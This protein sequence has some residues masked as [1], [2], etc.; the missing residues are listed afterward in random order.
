M[1]QSWSYLE[2][3]IVCKFYLN[4]VETWRNHID[5]L[6]DSLVEAGFPDRDK[7]S[8]RMR[9]QNYESL[10]IGKGLS[11]AGKQSKDIYSAMMNR[12]NSSESYKL[13]RTSLES[14]NI[15]GL[16]ATPT[17]LNQYLSVSAPTGD[18]FYKVFWKYFRAS[19]LTDPQVYHSCNMGKDTFWRIANDKN[20]GITKKTVV[21]LCFGLKLSYDDSL[22]LLD[23]AGYTL[24]DGIAFD[25]IVATYLQKK[26]YDVNDVNLTLAE[27]N[28]PGS[29]YLLPK[30]RRSKEELEEAK[31]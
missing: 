1:A 27:N 28:V 14:N 18:S 25:Y 12:I 13:L 3:Y 24:S 7:G 10:H 4:N 31:K 17:N 19:G 11:H 21:Q 6:M 8:A 20:E 29:L 30:N 22:V 5:L 9:V 2:D 16:I 15:G 26:I 23:A